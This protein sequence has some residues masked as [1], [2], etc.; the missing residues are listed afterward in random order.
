VLLQVADIQLKDAF[1]PDT[2][3]AQKRSQ[4][5]SGSAKKKLPKRPLKTFNLPKIFF[6]SLSMKR[7]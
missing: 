6:E 1:T 7:S 2:K 3:Y 4:Y 5:G